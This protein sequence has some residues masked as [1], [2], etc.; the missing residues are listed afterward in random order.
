MKKLFENWREFEKD[1]LVEETEKE[2]LEKIGADRMAR[3]RAQR[4][5]IKAAQAARGETDKTSDILSVARGE[6]ELGPPPPDIAEVPKGYTGNQPTGP[7][8]IVKP[9]ARAYKGGESPKQMVAGEY[10]TG[11]EDPMFQQGGEI[12]YGFSSIGLGT[13][14]QALAGN[15][16]L[17]SVA[18]MLSSAPQAGTIMS[19]FVGTAARGLTAIP[20][21]VGG[22]ATVG[23]IAGMVV[24][25]AL[26][27]REFADFGANMLGI[28]DPLAL[29]RIAYK[30][31]Q[32]ALGMQGDL[33]GHQAARIETTL[34]ILNDDG[35][36]PPHKQKFGGKGL[37]GA[38]RHALV[39]LA[40]SEHETGTPEHDKY[41]AELTAVL[42]RDAEI[43]E[44]GGRTG[45]QG[46]YYAKMMMHPRVQDNMDSL[47]NDVYSIAVGEGDDDTKAV[48][49]VSRLMAMDST[50]SDDKFHSLIGRERSEEEITLRDSKV[51]KNLT[52]QLIDP[53][54]RADT[55]ASDADALNNLV[56][57][58]FSAGDTDT[59]VS[60]MAGEFTSSPS[61]GGTWE[62]KHAQDAQADLQADQDQADYEELHYGDEAT[63]SFP[64]QEELVT[65]PES[66]VSYDD[67]DAFASSGHAARRWDDIV[68][69]TKRK[70][71]LS[72]TK[73]RL[74]Q[75][76]KEELTSLKT[77][78]FFDRF[79]GNAGLTD[80]EKRIKI[81][82]KYGKSIDG[83]RGLKAEVVT[84]E[85]GETGLQITVPDNFFG[86]E[87][88]ETRFFEDWR[89]AS[90]Y[91]QWGEGGSAAA[92]AWPAIGA[93]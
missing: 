38:R 80:E 22:V 76:I 7:K 15:A 13:V 44:E 30:Y 19:P 3:K 8:R 62:E 55:D 92:M 16:G 31:A 17:G 24:G 51:T 28:E 93:L 85:T 88:G 69:E 50:I 27:G 86:E 21:S 1:V 9:G 89:P 20:S 56:D 57:F 39:M 82:T 61:E 71:K 84:L 25:G 81:L 45:K 12:L 29:R 37:G 68:Y 83:A 54:L 14:F 32:G 10:E 91:I 4:D 53:S 65:P 18:T 35:N 64:D 11:L 87:K 70:P 43:Y 40:T 58:A 41:K 46:E 2:R 34:K 5:Q 52:D 59:A 47:L 79:T 48:G 66:P 6:K 77:E 78:A 63:Q 33:T 42:N 23:L 67:E 90:Q 75:I 60:A 26:L 72:I 73:Y 74:A 49:R 36:L